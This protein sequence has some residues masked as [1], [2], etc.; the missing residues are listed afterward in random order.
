MPVTQAR[1]KRSTS[2]KVHMSPISQAERASFGVHLRDMHVTNVHIKGRH[3]STRSFHMLGG[4]LAGAY[5]TG[6]HTH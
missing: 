2:S 4:S 1:T 5:L 3:L 6:G